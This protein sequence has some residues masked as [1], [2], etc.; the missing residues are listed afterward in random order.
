MSEEGLS[1]RVRNGAGR[2]PLS[3]ATRARKEKVTEVSLSL[4]AARSSEVVIVKSSVVTAFISRFMLNKAV[5][6]KKDERSISTGQLKA[7]LLLHIRPINL[8][9][10]KGTSG[11]VHLGVGFPLRCFQ[12]LSHPCVA[13]RR[14]SWQNNRCTS[15]T[16]NPVLSY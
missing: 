15:G 12:R 7:L 6:I 14:C 9:V 3:I 4:R 8:V 11:R 16:S 2:F 5:S 1:F 10:F 13:T